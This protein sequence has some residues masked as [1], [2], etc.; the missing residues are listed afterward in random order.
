MRVFWISWYIRNID[1]PEVASS[2]PEG[3]K[4]WPNEGRFPR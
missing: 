1:D 4:A 2:W 3:M